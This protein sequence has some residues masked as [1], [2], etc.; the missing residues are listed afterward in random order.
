MFDITYWEKLI[1][2]SFLATA[3]LTEFP[4]GHTVVQT[5]VENPHLGIVF[6]SLFQ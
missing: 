4:A 6:S 5:Q 3:C 1:V 2:N